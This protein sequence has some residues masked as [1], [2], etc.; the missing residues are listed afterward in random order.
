MLWHCLPKLSALYTCWGILQQKLYKT[1]LKDLQ[2]FLL[3]LSLNSL[4]VLGFQGEKLNPGGRWTG[5]STTPI[6]PSIF[7]ASLHYILCSCWLQ[8]QDQTWVG[9]IIGCS[10]PSMAMIK[11]GGWRVGIA[12]SREIW[13]WIWDVHCDGCCIAKHIFVPYLC[14]E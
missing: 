11:T 4:I 1:I 8:L 7:S 3:F 10:S 2:K 5:H 6:A 13:L 9:H 14:I 12:V